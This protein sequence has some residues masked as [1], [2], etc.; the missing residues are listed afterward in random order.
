MPRVFA[1][2]YTDPMSRFPATLIGM[3]RLNLH[4]F[5][6]CHKAEFSR[7]ANFLSRELCFNKKKVQAPREM[8]SSKDL[9]G[10]LMVVKVAFQLL[11]FKESQRHYV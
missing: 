9:A 7:K 11:F 5:W 3:G 8:L 1:G 2:Y 10:E 4:R 6:T